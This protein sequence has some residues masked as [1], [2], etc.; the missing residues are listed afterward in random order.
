VKSCPSC[1]SCPSPSSP[2]SCPCRSI[3]GWSPSSRLRFRFGWAGCLRRPGPKHPL[4]SMSSFNDTLFWW[5][6]H[7]CSS[8]PQSDPFQCCFSVPTFNVHDGL[9]MLY[10]YSC[11]CVPNP[12]ML[13]MIHD[14]IIFIR[15]IPNFFYSSP[16]VPTNPLPAAR[17]SPL[18]SVL[19]LAAVFQGTVGREP[20]WFAS[21]LAPFFHHP[22]HLHSRDFPIFPEKKNIQ[23]KR[24]HDQTLA[25]KHMFS[26]LI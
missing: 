9:F 4:G 3:A 21:K 8:D 5:H 15:F 18:L 20:A 11:Y 16:H 12:F 17:D 26:T 14:Q 2:R 1:P 7:F 6:S 25:I 13:T 22:M 24:P 23:K 10:V 19:G